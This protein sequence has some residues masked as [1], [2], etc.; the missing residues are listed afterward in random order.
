MCKELQQVEDCRGRTD[1]Y[2]FNVETRRVQPLWGHVKLQLVAISG[3]RPRTSGACVCC[4]SVQSLDEL[5]LYELH[6]TENH[7]R[8]RTQRLPIVLH[9]NMESWPLHVIL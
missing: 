2:A 5:Y 1:C 4:Y 3:G 6:A 7:E 9:D 8:T